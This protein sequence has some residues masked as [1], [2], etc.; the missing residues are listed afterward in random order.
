MCQ[1]ETQN[2]KYDLSARGVKERTEGVRGSS[3]AVTG[4]STLTFTVLCGDEPIHL[5][6][7]GGL[8][9]EILTECYV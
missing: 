2:Y 7:L 4:N 1:V 8:K 5:K 6:F 3:A 9:N